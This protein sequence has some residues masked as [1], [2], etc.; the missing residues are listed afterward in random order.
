M[1]KLLVFCA[2]ALIGFAQANEKAAS[3]HTIIKQGVISSGVMYSHKSANYKKEIKNQ[4]KY[5]VGF[6]N[7]ISS[8]I[9]FTRVKIES[10]QSELISEQIYKVTYKASFTLAINKDSFLAQK[11]LLKYRWS[12]L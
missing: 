9:D 1:M 4:L 6:Y 10:I 12:F 7:E 8:G 3:F 2:L 11:M 5:L